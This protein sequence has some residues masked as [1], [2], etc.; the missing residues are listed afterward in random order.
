VLGND[1]HLLGNEVGGVETDTELT[2]HGDISTSGQGLHE[3]LGSRASNGSQVVDHV[4]LGHT[5]TRVHKSQGLV[6][7]VG[8]DVDEEV[9]FSIQHTLVSQGLVTD[10]VKS[11]RRVGDQLPQ[12]DFLVG[13]ESVDDQAHQLVDFSLEGVSFGGHGFEDLLLIKYFNLFAY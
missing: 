5:D 8:Q 10:L 12:E 3:L 2:N 11:I 6:G 1:N 7:L 13:V 9:G 4:G